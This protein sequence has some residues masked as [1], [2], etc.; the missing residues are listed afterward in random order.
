[1]KMRLPC[2]PAISAIVSTGTVPEAIST[3]P[4]PGP[5]IAATS[6]SNSEMSLTVDG[7]GMPPHPEWLDE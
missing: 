1:M 4:R 5:P 3:I 2:R 7:I 6:A